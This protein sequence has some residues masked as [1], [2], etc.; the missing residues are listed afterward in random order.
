MVPPQTEENLGTRLELAYERE[1]FAIASLLLSSLGGLAACLALWCLVGIFRAT[2]LCK[3]RCASGILS[4]PTSL[5]RLTNQRTGAILVLASCHL[6]FA[7]C[8]HLVNRPTQQSML[9]INTYSWTRTNTDLRVYTCTCIY[10]YGDMCDVSYY[11]CIGHGHTHETCKA[12]SIAS[13]TQKRQLHVG[14]YVCKLCV[15]SLLPHIV[16]NP[17]YDVVVLGDY[18]TQD[19]WTPLHVAS[20]NGHRETVEVLLEHSADVNTR[21]KV[22]NCIRWRFCLYWPSLRLC[23]HAYCTSSLTL[24]SSVSLSMCFASC[25]HFSTGS[26]CDRTVYLSHLRSYVWVSTSHTLPYICICTPVLVGE[27]SWDCTM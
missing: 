3:E 13:N 21:N 22:C 14:C 17:W 11:M 1:T 7:V 18:L 5:R 2:A 12:I 10:L 25:T 4:L 6:W 19:G 26:I 8:L 9:G 24:V 16:M 15:H 23:V 20:Q 27:L